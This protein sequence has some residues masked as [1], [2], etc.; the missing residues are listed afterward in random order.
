VQEEDPR[1]HARGDGLDPPAPVA[2][3]HPRAAQ[4]HRARDAAV[5]QPDARRRGFLGRRGDADAAW[6]GGRTSGRRT[7]SRRSRTFAGRPGARTHRLEPD[8]GRRV[9]RSEPRSDSLPRREVPARTKITRAG[10]GLIPTDRRR[11]AELPVFPGGERGTTVALRRGMT[12]TTSETIQLRTASEGAVTAGAPMAAP[13]P[14]AVPVAPLA[15]VGTLPAPISLD[16]KVREFEASLIKWALRATHG[17]KSKAA[18][19][20]QVKRST[21]GDRIVR[22][23]LVDP[24][25]RPAPVEQDG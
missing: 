14:P 25:E 20:L 9:A 16:D 17:N 4:R 8:E 5:G 7:Q 2:G 21:L 11:L 15:P 13:A 3:Q 1:R 23:G 12:I 24:P 6:R 18:A 19:L 22:C 10:C